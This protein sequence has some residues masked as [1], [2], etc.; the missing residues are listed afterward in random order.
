LPGIA[1]EQLNLQN[2]ISF[3]VIQVVF[4]QLPGKFFD[5]LLSLNA[6]VMAVLY[7]FLFKSARDNQVR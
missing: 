7:E 2:Q 5:V 4:R 3:P 1:S 6:T